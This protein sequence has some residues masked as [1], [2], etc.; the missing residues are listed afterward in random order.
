MR[1]SKLNFSLFVF[2]I[3]FSIQVQVAAGSGFDLFEG[4]GFFLFFCSPSE[5]FTS[6]SEYEKFLDF[7]LSDISSNT[8]PTSYRLEY[9]AVPGQ[10]KDWIYSLALCRGDMPIFFDCNKCIAEAGKWLRK[11]CPLNKAAIAWFEGC[12]LKYSNN[13]FI[14]KIDSTGPYYVIRKQNESSPAPV[15]I[16]QKFL[17]HLSGIAS[18]SNKKFAKGV[19]KLAGQKDQLFG[20]VQCTLDLSTEECKTCID[21]LVSYVPRFTGKGG[22]FVSGTC[23]IQ[24]EFSPFFNA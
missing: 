22:H 4:L 8:P 23:S 15:E 5:N 9:G 20:L 13:N 1:C 3:A 7:I 10:D 18:V 11:S 21:G 6:E 24:Y 19:F 16:I 14:G 12:L 2:S 17:T